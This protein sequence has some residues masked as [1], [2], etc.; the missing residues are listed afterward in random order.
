M[1][2]DLVDLVNALHGGKAG[3]EQ[4]TAE[5]APVE[6]DLVVVKG[7][8]L[9]AEDHSHHLHLHD[10]QHGVADVGM[11]ERVRHPLLRVIS[12]SQTPALSAC[13]ALVVALQMHKHLTEDR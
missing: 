7:V 13:A 2:G 6:T 3:G 10:R 4:K 1:A 5:D 8:H 11:L 9:P 12:A